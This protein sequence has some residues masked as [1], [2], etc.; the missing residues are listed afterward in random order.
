MPFVD[1]IH[2][3]LQLPAIIAEKLLCLRQVKDILPALGLWLVE[4]GHHE[5]VPQNPELRVVLFAEIGQLRKGGLLADVAFPAA[6]ITGPQT[7]HQGIHL[8]LLQRLCGP[9]PNSR[10]SAHLHEWKGTCAAH[11]GRNE[12]VI[13]TARSLD[14]RRRFPAPVADKPDPHARRRLR[15][16]RIRVGGHA[17]RP[18]ASDEQP[19]EKQAEGNAAF[20]CRS[21]L[22]LPRGCPLLNGTPAYLRPASGSP[23]RE[24]AGFRGH[25][26]VHGIDGRHGDV[27]DIGTGGSEE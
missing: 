12:P 1:T 11:G 8:P 3:G 15:R 2:L 24:Q 13:R 20:S 21:H 5:R 16:F 10:G 9:F 17:H 19:D 23:I 4:G 7:D 25:W 6:R 27:V 14:D 22:G 26:Q 18:P